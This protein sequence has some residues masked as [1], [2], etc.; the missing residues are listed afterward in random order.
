MKLDEAIAK[1]GN[2]DVDESKIKEVLGVKESKVW[3]PKF[4]ETYY[5]FTDGG[6]GVSNGCVDE[7][8]R[9][10]VG[11]FYKTL[12]EAEFARHKQIFL[13]KFERYLKENEY[14]PVDW[15]NINQVKFY[16]Q[17]VNNDDNSILNTASLRSTQYQGTIYTTNK[18][19]I[20]KFIEENKADIKKYMFGV[21]MGERIIEKK[22]Q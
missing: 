6:V 3:K 18:F 9:F 21:K 8:S 16:I 20:E 13:T 19:T 1:Y 17:L 11:N 2:A 14:E 5:Y 10:R 15:G 22:D 7:S 12:E 4:G